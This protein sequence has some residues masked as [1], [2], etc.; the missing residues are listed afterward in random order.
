M[1]RRRP[2][3]HVRPIVSLLLAIGCGTTEASRFYL[4]TPMPAAAEQARADSAGPAIVL[5]PLEIPEYLDRPEIVTHDGGPIIALAEFDR[6]A[7]PLRQNLARVLAENLSALLRTERVIAFADRST[8]PRDCDVR[9]SV[10]SFDGVPGEAITLVARF[11]VVRHADSEA[12]IIRKAVIVKP[13]GPGRDFATFV[14]AA[15]AAVAELSQE[16]AAAIRG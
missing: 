9:V 1:N 15:S 8:Q 6:W 3:T 13:A 14:A 12:S 5:G 4:L 2:G 7:E 11:T 10:V 16:I